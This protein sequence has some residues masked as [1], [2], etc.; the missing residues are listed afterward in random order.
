MQNPSSKLPFITFEGCECSGKSTQSKLLYDWL[1]SNNKKVIL[2]KEPGG[3]KTAE[4]LREFLLDKKKKLD[5]RSEALLHVA[6]RVEHVSDVIL[7]ALKVGT[8]VIC[9][10]FADSTMAYQSYGH[11]I[12]AEF[13]K[14]LHKNLLNNIESAI[15]FLLDINI[16]TFRRRLKAKLATSG[17]NDRYEALPEEFHIKVINGFKTISK[18]NPKRFVVIDANDRSISEIHEEITSHILNL[19]PN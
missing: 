8:I 19:F 1:I 5:P 2:T 10:R 18:E 6:A 13:L 4:E 7:P 15:T 12:P 3:T 11:G 16:D 9:D 17:N 14:N